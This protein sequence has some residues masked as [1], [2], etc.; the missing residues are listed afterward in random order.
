MTNLLIPGSLGAL[1][2]ETGKPLAESFLSA[3]AIVLVDVSGSMADQIRAPEGNWQSRYERACQELERLQ[4][5][6][7]GK[8]AVVEF[9]SQPAFCW[10]GRPAFQMGGTDMAEA[11]R[12]VQPA[13][14]CGLTFVLISDGMPDDAGETLQVARQFTDAIQCIYIGESDGDAGAA[15]LRRLA[16]ATGG[17]ASTNRVPELASA[18]AGLLPGKAA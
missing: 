11:L 18:I 10:S 7:P 9:S 16:A 3:D 8:I 14:G 17:K 4:R 1:A 6:L 2:K 13:D 12:F 5:T 15:F